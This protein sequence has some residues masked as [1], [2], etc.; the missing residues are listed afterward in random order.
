MYSERPKAPPEH[1]EHHSFR[2]LNF[3]NLPPILWRRYPY[4]CLDSVPKSKSTPT[5]Q[6]AKNSEIRSNVNSS[7]V[8]ALIR[9]SKVS[10]K[11]SVRAIGKELNKPFKGGSQDIVRCAHSH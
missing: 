8:E 5:E 9:G 3:I 2:K 10:S 6:T 1:C 7:Q 11:N 4:E